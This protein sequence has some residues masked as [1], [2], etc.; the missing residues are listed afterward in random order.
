MR[1]GFDINGE[2]RNNL[3]FCPDV[4]ELNPVLHLIEEEL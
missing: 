3:P 2:E 4:Q 1:K